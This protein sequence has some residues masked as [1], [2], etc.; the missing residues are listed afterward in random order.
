[1]PQQEE[2]PTTPLQYA[3][4]AVKVRIE[5]R[6]SLLVIVQRISAGNGRQKIWIERSMIAHA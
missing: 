2:E 6:Y 1:M 5:R 4:I 3:V